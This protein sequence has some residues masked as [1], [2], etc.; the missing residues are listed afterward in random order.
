MLFAAD[1]ILPRLVPTLQPADT[2]VGQLIA[3]SWLGVAALNWLSRNQLLGGIYGRP[4]VSANT[5]LY[6]VTAMSMVKLVLRPATPAAVW[7][8]AVPMAIFAAIYMW[9]LLRGPVTSD[10]AAFGAK[11]D[12][13]G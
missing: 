11:A 6:F 4:V 10:L 5:L 12:K 7:I 3:A 8:V 2:W 1:N 13:R 9:L